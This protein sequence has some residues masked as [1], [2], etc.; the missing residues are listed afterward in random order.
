MNAQIFQADIG[1]FYCPIESAI[2]PDVDDVARRSM[3]WADRFG[4]C[5]DER[6]RKRLMA[7]N[8]AEF[9]CRASP[10]AVKDRL[11]IASDWNY[12]GFTFDDCLVDSQTFDRTTFVATVSRLLRII[13]TLDA[14]LCDGNP[15]LMAMHDM[16]LRFSRQS[17]PVQ[18]KRWLDAH[19]EWL[20]GTVQRHALEARGEAPGLDAYL[21]MRLHDCG[22]SMVTAPIEFVNGFEVSGD[23][24]NSPAV[25]ALTEVTWMVA[26][27]D[28]ERVSRTKEI[29]AEGEALNL[30]NE[31]MREHGCSQEEALRRFVAMRDRMMCLFLQL[32]EQVM[33]HAS[34]ELRRYVTD[35]GHVIRGNID[36]S[37]STGR[38]NTI[39][40]TEDSP[41]GTV[42]LSSGWTL[43]S[44]DSRLE[45]LL[46]PAIA[47]WWEQLV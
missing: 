24:M 17:T 8:A 6:R 7:I 30:I 13:E 9:V 3:E 33:S 19:R 1:L 29:H 35:L 42:N 40:G 43:E 31:L 45:P 15:Y 46:N 47:W 10:E 14:R 23:E 44:A 28:N 26:A 2:H 38:Y 5:A 4:L 39:Y 27:L 37:L 16:A 41:T 21:I 25:R 12:W 34:P 20:F 36:W 22:G 11:Q 32:R 18:R